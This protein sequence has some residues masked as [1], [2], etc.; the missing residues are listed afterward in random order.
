MNPSGSTDTHPLA[1]LL[2]MPV[3]KPE[4]RVN[5]ILL[6]EDRLLCDLIAEKLGATGRG[7]SQAVRFGLRCA[8][9]KLGIVVGSEGK[10]KKKKR[11]G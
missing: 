7:R 10:E 6:A 2:P 9:E 11:M 5:V 1:T 8:A 3:T 4:D